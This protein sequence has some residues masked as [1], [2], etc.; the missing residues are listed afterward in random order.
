M[1]LKARGGALA[2]LLFSTAATAHVHQMNK[3]AEG[4]AVSEDPIDSILW[5]HIL[6]QSLAWGIIFP[7]GMVLGVS[8]RKALLDK[9]ARAD[10]SPR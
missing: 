4:S 9:L 1:G 7:T 2:V 3:I 6:V 10:N 5:I 8:L